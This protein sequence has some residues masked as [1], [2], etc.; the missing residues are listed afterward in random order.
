[1][2]QLL[3][4]EDE[5]GL[6][7]LY[8]LTLIRDGYKVETAKNGQEAIAK[9]KSSPPDLMILDIMLPNMNGFH[10]AQ[11]ILKDPAIAK[12]PKLL[13]ITGRDTS[14]EKSLFELLGASGVMEK[15]FSL[16]EMKRTVYRIL[17]T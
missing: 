9:V 2:K 7:N 17:N 13:F 16:E 15:P 1:M 3:I 5:E 8:S 11:S 14:K 6:L 10:V 12:K 4:V